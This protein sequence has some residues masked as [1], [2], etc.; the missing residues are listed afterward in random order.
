MTTSVSAHLRSLD[1]VRDGT[2]WGHLSPAAP[3]VDGHCACSPCA[4]SVVCRTV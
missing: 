2:P 3:F 4:G 1:T